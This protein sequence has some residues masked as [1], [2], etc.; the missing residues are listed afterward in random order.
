MCLKI[1][2]N[3]YKVRRDWLRKEPTKFSS[4]N[5]RVIENSKHIIIKGACHTVRDGKNIDV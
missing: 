2:K 1:L 3:K 5:W 4:P